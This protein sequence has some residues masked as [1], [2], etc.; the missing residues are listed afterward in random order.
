MN[1]RSI[2]M[3]SF[4]VY[5]SF[6]PADPRLPWLDQGPASPAGYVTSRCC[7]SSAGSL[8]SGVGC[9]HGRVLPLT[10][11]FTC[12]LLH[13]QAL[14]P[15]SQLLLLFPLSDFRPSPME[16]KAERDPGSMGES[17]ERE[18]V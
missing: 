15:F 9:I 13:L 4:P 12:K 11:V 10:S 1:R 14:A 5:S 2:L 7:L 18:V 16:A 8:S 6:S 17:R 3:S